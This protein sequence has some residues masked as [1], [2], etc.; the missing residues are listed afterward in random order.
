MAFTSLC[1]KKGFFINSFSSLPQCSNQSTVFDSSL[2]WFSLPYSHDHSGLHWEFKFSLAITQNLQSLSKTYIFHVILSITQKSVFAIFVFSLSFAI[3]ATYTHSTISLS[4]PSK[5]LIPFCLLFNI[6][7]K[8]L[9]SIGLSS[10]AIFNVNLFFWKSIL[11]FFH[12][13]VTLVL[14]SKFVVFF[15]FSSF[16][17]GEDQNDVGKFILLLELNNVQNFF[18]TQ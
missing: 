12:F 9:D 3:N 5:I 8:S 7:H 10:H 18:S 6:F 2:L 1:I 4:I 14:K 15:R 17:I 13:D 16:L 11:T